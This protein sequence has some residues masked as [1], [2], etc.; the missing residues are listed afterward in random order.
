MMINK[1]ILIIIAFISSVILLSAVVSA[2]S[3]SKV[4]SVNNYGKCVS[5]ETKEKNLCFRE[6]KNDFKE[7]S[8][9]AK[10]STNKTLVKENKKI[11]NDI[12]KNS[13]NTCKVEFKMQKDLCSLNKIKDNKNYC[14]NESRNAGACIDLYEPV[15]GWFNP[16]K[17]QCFRY[18]C[19]QT[20]SNSCNAC[21]NP[22]VLFWTD[23]ECP[24]RYESLFL[25]RN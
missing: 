9:D 15:C 14:T 17:I 6:A 22:D 3:D 19:G 20:Y 8:K 13:I 24:K 10:N 11:C 25:S 1:K 2:A 5:N 18:P 23:G 7:C 4:E 12:Y 16:S 21:I